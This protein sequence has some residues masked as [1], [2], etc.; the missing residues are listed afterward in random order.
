MHILHILYLSFGGSNSFRVALFQHIKVLLFWVFQSSEY[1][2]ITG[3]GDGSMKKLL[4][5]FAGTLLLLSS[6]QAGTKARSNKNPDQNPDR[7]TPAPRAAGI[8]VAPAQW[9]FFAHYTYSTIT[10]YYTFEVGSTNAGVNMIDGYIFN[11]PSSQ[12]DIRAL[13]LFDV[14]GFTPGNYS[15][16]VDSYMDFDANVVDIFDAE[17]FG[18]ENA[19]PFVDPSL[20]F[21]ALPGPPIGSAAILGAAT[22]TTI[23]F[24]VSSQV[25]ADIAGGL[26]GFLLTLENP[27]AAGTWDEWGLADARLEQLVFSSVPTMNEVGLT[28]FAV[29]FLGLGIYLIRRK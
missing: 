2:I 3:N 12:N 27:A 1:L 11:Y 6:I 20:A 5:F 28:L 24:N 22:P 14:S 4:I 16:K 9:G 29:L 19:N 18:L 13:Y 25:N 23:D 17:D 21:G 7:Y 26:S 15:F 8:E 10:S